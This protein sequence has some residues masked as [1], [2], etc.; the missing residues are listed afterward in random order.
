MAHLHEVATASPAVRLSPVANPTEK[1]PKQPP[2]ARVE[3]GGM[4][5]SRPALPEGGVLVTAHRAD[6]P[7]LRTE[8]RNRKQ[9]DGT[10]DAPEVPAVLGALS[11]QQSPTAAQDQPKP[12]DQSLA[13]DDP[14]RRLRRS[15]LNNLTQMDDATLTQYLATPEGQHVAT[16]LHYYASHHPSSSANQKANGILGRVPDLP[17]PAPGHR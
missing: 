17:S 16:L 14:E 12:D 3:A 7:A 5:A 4:R 10:V 15:L 2:A 9:Q 6:N 1:T 8:D 11:P 13:G